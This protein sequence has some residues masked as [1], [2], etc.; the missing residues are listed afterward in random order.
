MIP[1]PTINEQA[2]FTVLLRPPR[3]PPR[4]PA[5]VILLL[6]PPAITAFCPAPTLARPLSTPADSAF[7]QF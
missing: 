4:V 3:I 5:E 6:H 1:L 2:V 7:A